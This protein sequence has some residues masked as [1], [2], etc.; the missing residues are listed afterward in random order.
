MEE[1]TEEEIKE[2]MNRNGV[3]EDDARFIIAL[4][5][6]EIDGDVFELQPGEDMPE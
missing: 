6:G 4:G 2:V 1:P 5:R 3:D